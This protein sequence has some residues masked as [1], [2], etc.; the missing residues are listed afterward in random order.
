MTSGLEVQAYNETHGVV[1]RLTCNVEFT[2][3]LLVIQH[4]HYAGTSNGALG[5]HRR[6]CCCSVGGKTERRVRKNNGEVSLNP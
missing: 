6:W 2:A 3:V 4:C 1:M 5:F